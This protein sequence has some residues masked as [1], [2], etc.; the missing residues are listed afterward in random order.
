MIFTRK[1]A[2]AIAAGRKTQMRL[3]VR[4]PRFVQRTRNGKP[5]GPVY[6]SRPFEP[7]AGDSIPIAIK[8]RPGPGA[9]KA[10]PELVARVVVLHARTEEVGAITFEGARA[11]GCKTTAEFKAN[12]VR[13][14]EPR[15]PPVERAFCPTCTGVDYPADE[16]P[17]CPMCDGEETILIKPTPDEDEL[18]A[19]FD[20]RHADRLVHVITFEVDKTAEL[21]LL[22]PAARR[23]DDGDEH[24]YTTDQRRALVGDRD[25]RGRAIPE[26]EAIDTDQL[27]AA[28]KVDATARHSEARSE[29]QR[30]TAARSL[31]RRVRQAALNVG[32]DELAELER[33]VQAIERG[34]A[35][36]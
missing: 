16:L 33:Q 27:N 23:T 19:R 28:W 10:P 5:N 2:T 18:A 7:S 15:W 34:E 21:R 14:H 22:S 3:L 31:A 36:A 26:P 24:G 30:R 6:T 17:P 11:E 29:E 4:E 1:V 8:G 25:D 9:T 32:P 13:L 12:W 20:T 35:A